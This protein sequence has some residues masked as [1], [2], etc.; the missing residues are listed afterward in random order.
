[1]TDHAEKNSDTPTGAASGLSGGLAGSA[2]KT[3]CWHCDEVYVRAEEACPHCCATNANHDLELAQ[4]EME[5][6]GSISHDW[7]LKDDS[8][9]C[10][11]CGAIRQT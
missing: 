1:M 5:N 8:W 3:L 10:D 6:D 11:L 7:K 4:W 2:E 9:K